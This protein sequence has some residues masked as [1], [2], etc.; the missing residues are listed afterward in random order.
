MARLIDESLLQEEY[1]PFEEQRQI[2]KAKQQKKKKRRIKR[3]ARIL[4]VFVVIAAISSI[5]FMMDAS[6]VKS[7]RVEHDSYLSEEY[8][9]DKANITYDSR[10]L[11]IFSPIVEFVMERDACIKNANVKHVK[12]QGIVIDVEEEQAVGYF[13]DDEQL[14]LLLGNGKTMKMS[15]SYYS[16]LKSLPFIKD[17]NSG[18]DSKALANELSKLDYKIISN[19]AEIW[20]YTSSYDQNM[21]R[22][23]MA[24]GHQ[25]FT[26]IDAIALLQNYNYITENLNKKACLVLD[27][28]QN[29][30]YTQSCNELNEAEKKAIEKNLLE[31]STDIQDNLENNVEENKE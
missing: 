17:T 6:K 10:Y 19:I 11:L 20:N 8:I 26:N 28:Q 16:V 4:L 14:R 2:K 25:V 31:N 22:L 21:I 23:I 9:L 30:A 5:Y 1:D 3:I 12:N 29:V 15:S 13:W 27:L 24:D 18:L 7:I